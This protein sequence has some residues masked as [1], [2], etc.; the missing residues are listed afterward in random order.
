MRSNRTLIPVLC[1]CCLLTPSLVMAQRDKAGDKKAAKETEDDKKEDNGQHLRMI[2]KPVLV[3]KAGAEL[4]TRKGVVWKAYLGEVFTV[5]EVEGE[6]YWIREKGGWLWEKH[7]VP[8][9]SAV[10]R[11]SIEIERRP[12]AEAFHQRGIAYAAI[13]D[14]E[15]SI[16]DY[17][18]TIELK[19][20][21]A[22]AYVNRGNCYR[23]MKNQKKA[24]SD[25][26]AALTLDEK[27]FVAY[28]NRA[29][30]YTS[31]RE[32][33]KAMGDLDKAVSLSK[34]YA[35][36]YNNRG[37]VWREKGDLKK[38]LG[39]YSRAL[40]IYPE[41]WEALRNIGFAHNKLGNYEAAVTAYSEA[42]RLRPFEPVSLNNIA[43]MA[44]TCP[45]EEFRNARLAL[46]DA[47]KACEY[48]KNKDWNSL[49]TLGAA[50]A[51]NQMFDKAAEAAQRALKLAP[52]DQKADIKERIKLYEN[53]KPFRT[54][55]VGPKEDAKEKDADKT[56]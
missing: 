36:A 7:T 2:G 32:F 45:R 40:K 50:Y 46:D 35:E 54:V 38:A 5:A 20:Q 14:Y 34:E 24:L 17:S 39:D 1:F 51:E 37:V 11:F 27:N 8:L 55:D 28:N 6:W 9:D 16:E 47:K 53:D 26:S 42:A 25:F 12:S 4:K 52:K 30:V 10:E 49:D 43:W 41:F 19:P 31:M 23:A 15:R 33:D 56:K 13:E 21:Y 29:L 48:T 18:K 44:A 3:T 22:G